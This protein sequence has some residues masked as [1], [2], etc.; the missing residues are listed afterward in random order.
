MK[1]LTD[2]KSE[3]IDKLRIIEQKEL[4]ALVTRKSIFKIK[5]SPIK[6]YFKNLKQSQKLKKL[7]GI[8]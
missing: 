8:L 5:S 7:K 2:L 1:L 6:F 4:L 3:T